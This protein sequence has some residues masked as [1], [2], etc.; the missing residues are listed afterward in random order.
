M[1]DR[2]VS[3]SDHRVTRNQKSYL[4]PPS[5]FKN[6]SPVLI[7]ELGAI[8]HDNLLPQKKFKL[9]YVKTRHDIRV[10]FCE[11]S[12]RLSSFLEAFHSEP[13]LIVQSQPDKR[14]THDYRRM[15]LVPKRSFFTGLVLF[16]ASRLR[17]GFGVPTILAS[18]VSALDFGPRRRC[19]TW[20]LLF[21]REDRRSDLQ[22]D[23]FSPENSES[24]DSEDQSSASL[25]LK[26]NP[27]GRDPSSF[28]FQDRQVPDSFSSRPDQSEFDNAVHYA[29]D[30]CDRVLRCST[31][32]GCKNK[33]STSLLHL[34]AH[35]LQE[36]DRLLS[37]NPVKNRRQR[38]KNEGHG[39]ILGLGYERGDLDVQFCKIRRISESTLALSR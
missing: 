14:N 11:H 25:Y 38:I 39:N 27:F 12:V 8:Q 26:P 6:L 13:F 5:R 24:R 1:H 30:L 18:L 23:Y 19:N 2:N 7:F 3:R 16:S 22:L 10:E 9:L 31:S 17:R 34:R 37:V 20:G 15:G 21:C 35:C 4:S 33:Q 36:I 32:R 29:L 28:H